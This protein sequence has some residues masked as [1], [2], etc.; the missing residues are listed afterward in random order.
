MV[1][2]ALAAALES[3]G[4]AVVGSAKVHDLWLEALSSLGGFF[5]PIT[6]RR[7]EDRFESIRTEA[8]RRYR[9]QL[10]CEAVVLTDVRDVLAPWMNSQ[11][12]WDGAADDIGAGV[13]IG[14][15]KA[16]SVWI[17]MTDLSNNEPIYFST[18]G[19]QALVSAQY[20]VF[21]GPQF[22][23]ISAAAL[24]P[25]ERVSRAIGLALRRVNAVP[26]G[27]GEEYEDGGRYWKLNT[28]LP[29][30]SPRGR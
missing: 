5:D 28:R 10:G 23:S 7:L 20:D 21:A 26:G 22:K 3:S 16:L 15:V 29:T 24:L 25:P 8:N 9:E 30:P 6:G 18:G 12:K 27:S 14:W 4:F 2:D 11:V 17:S 13:G 19:I 1:E